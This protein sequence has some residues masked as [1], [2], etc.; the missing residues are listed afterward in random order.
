M[1]ESLTYKVEPVKEP[2]P[3]TA[4]GIVV[5]GEKKEEKPGET[6]QKVGE[7]TQ[8]R[9]IPPEN[10][11]I[12]TVKELSKAEMEREEERK[13]TKE[14]FIEFYEKLFCLISRTCE[15]VGIDRTTYYEW[16]KNDSEFDKALKALEAKEDEFVLNK[17]K[18]AVINGDKPTIRF[19]ASK[20]L[21]GFNTTKIETEITP[22]KSLK[23][24]AEELE[25]ILKK[26]LDDK[27]AGNNNQQGP[28]G[29]LPDDPKQKGSDS[30]VQ[31]QP[32][33]G[34]ILAKK[35]PTQH[36]AQAKTGGVKQ[37]H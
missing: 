27:R 20:K 32:S 3:G 37:G 31:K 5:N 16:R 21:S 10:P 1:D 34:N 22:A 18:E 6:T 9:A 15:K 17:L 25:A 28:D 26:K 13:K 33:T 14:R 23:E 36:L 4:S 11:T 12:P 8:I 29:K 24:V 30:A 7:T 2:E 19:W 35:N